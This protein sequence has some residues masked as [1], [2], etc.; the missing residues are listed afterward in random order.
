MIRSDC[1]LK[2]K[3]HPSVPPWCLL[4]SLL[5]CF[6]FFSCYFHFIPTTAFI[7]CPLVLSFHSVLSLFIQCFRSILSCAFTSS[8][9]VF[10][11][12]P[13]LCF[14]LHYVLSSHP[15]S[16]LLSF[17]L[18]HIIRFDIITAHALILPPG[19]FHL[20]HLRFHFIPSCFLFTCLSFALI[21]FPV[22]N[23]LNSRLSFHCI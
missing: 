19:D 10:S 1:T 17:S 20:S 11:L 23:L 2:K 21:S 6:H 22:I 7:S 18:H 14:L 15:C 3:S 5:L 13:L 9:T 4:L 12:Y 8:H 16:F